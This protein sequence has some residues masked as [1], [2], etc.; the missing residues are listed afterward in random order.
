VRSFIPLY[1]LIFLA[2][3]VGA[4]DDC[5]GTSDKKAVGL[6]EK[7][8]ERKKYDKKKRMQFLRE[9]IEADDDFLAPRLEIAKQIIR[10]AKY[11]GSTIAPAVKH[12]KKII[13]LCPE[14]HSDPYFF[15]GEYYLEEEERFDLRK[16]S[17]HNRIN[18]NHK[19]QPEYYCK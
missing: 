11:Q 14:Y 6:Y 16:Y 4:Q 5:G 19:K 1:I 13:E 7:G 10:T 3:H 15:L 8:L 17:Y 18:N 2:S 12:F 9:S